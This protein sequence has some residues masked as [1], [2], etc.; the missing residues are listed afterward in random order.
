MVRSLLAALLLALAAEPARAAATTWV[1]GALGDWN[2]PTNWSAGSVPGPAD[3][4]A[5]SVAFVIAY[6]SSPAPSV[7]TLSV[8]SGGVLFTQKGLVSVGA[9]TVHL[10]GAL[11]FGATAPIVLGG[12]VMQSGSSATYVGP[13]VAAGTVPPLHVQAGLFSVAAGSTFTVAARGYA[14]GGLTTAGFGPGG[15]GLGNGLEGG[16]GGGHEAAGANGGGG[17]NAGVSYDG[18]LPTDG[19]SGGG[20]S[21]SAPGGAGGGFLVIDASTAS[22]DG[23]LT[24]DGEV[25]VASGG[26]GGGGGAGGAV[27]LRTAVLTG[28]GRI[29]AAGGA[30]GA[31]ASHGG[32]GG[33]GGAVWITESSGYTVL[34]STLTVSATGGAGG[35][36]AVPGSAAVAGTLYSDPRHWTG[37]GVG[38]FASNPLNWN[39]GILPQGGE[40]LVFGASTTALG[41]TWDLGAVTVGSVTVVNSY[42]ATVTL[43]SSMLVAGTFDMAAG[44]V[45]A[46]PSVDLAVAL[47]LSQT[48]GRL[49]VGV[50]T[51]TVAGAGVS[52]AASFYDAR[53]GILIVGGGGAATATVTGLLDVVTQA[54]LQPGGTL[55]LSTGVLRFEGQGPIYGTG[56]VNSSTSATV[57]AAG[58]IT[59][60][61]NAWP[62]ALGNLRDS[63]VSVTGLVLN[64]GGGAFTLTGGV[65]VDTISSLAF[66]GSR[67]NVGGDWAAY[68]TLFTAGSTVAFRAVVG[69]QTVW[70]GGNFDNLIVDDAGALL[71][72]ASYVVVADSVSLMSGTLDLAVSTL[73]VRGNWTETPG[74]VMLGGA[75]LTLFDGSRPQAIYQVGGNAFGTFRAQN[76]AQVTISSTLA[77]TADFRWDLGNLTYSNA[78]LVIGGNMLTGAGIILNVAGSTVVFN[79]FASTQATNFPQFGDFVDMNYGPYGVFVAANMSCASFRVLPGAVLN[80]G[81]SAVFVA[82]P[83]WDTGRATYT[84]SSPAHQ[85]YWQPTTTLTVGAGSVVNA[86]L[87]LDTGKTAVLNGD[88]NLQ[89]TGTSLD[90]RQGATLINA[91]GG[92]TLAFRGGA[93][94]KPS[95]GANWTYGGDVVDSWLVFEGTGLK[96]A[97]VSTTTF[98]TL[99]VTMNTTT[100]VFKAPSLNLLRGLI[101]ENGTFSASVAPTV[102]VGG[103]LLQ[104]GGVLDFA[105]NSTGTF[106]LTGAAPQNVRLVSGHNALYHFTDLNPTTVTLGS[107][108][109]ARG[110]FTVAAGVFNAGGGNLRL[111]NNVWIATGAVFNGQTSTTTFDGASGGHSSQ[112]LGFYGGGSFGALSF[113]VVTATLLTGATASVLSDALPGASLTVAAGA[114]LTVSDLRVNGTTGGAIALQS[115]AAGTP[116]YLDL[117]SYSSVTSA[118]VSDSNASLGLAVAADD[119]RDVDGGGNTNWKF[120]PQLLVLLPGESFT[121]GAAP[122]KTGAPFLST[123]GVAIPL[124]VLAVSSHYDLSTATGVV[125]LTSDDAFAALGAPQALAGGA[126]A[127]TVTP[128]AA[129]P[130]PRST[131]FTATT[132]FGSGLS[133]GSVI[134]AGLARLQLILPGEAAL[135]GSPTGRTG[136]AFPRVKAVPF[137]ATVRAVDQYWNA[138]T[139]VTDA[140]ALGTA[141]SSATLPGQPPLAAGLSTA[142]GLIFYTTGVFTISA[143]DLTEPGVIAA[144]SSLLGV[145]PPSVSS[146]TASF[147]VPTGASIATL[148]GAI[149]GTAADSSSIALVRVDILEVETGFHYDGISRFVSA[150][151]VFSTTT[152][153]SPLAASTSWSNP[154]PDAALTNGRHYSATALVE[155][156]SGFFGVVASTF[157]V[158]RSALSYGRR[159][160]QGTAAAL[161]GSAPGCALVTATVTFTVGAAGIGPGGAVA[162]RAPDGWT[163]PA[164]LI[165][166]RPPP[167]G[168]WNL[169]STSQVGVIGSSAVLVGPPAFGPQPLGPNWLV[170]AVGTGSAAS[171]LPGQQL[172]FE[173]TGMPPLTPQGRGRQLFQIW[174]TAD[175][176]APLAPISSQP[177]V[178]LTPGATSFLA[179]SDPTPLNLAPLQ[180]STTM[181][182]KV[183]DQCGNDTPGASSATAS[184]SLVVPAGGLYVPDATAAFALPSGLVV[185]T[186]GVPLGAPASQAFTVVTATSGPTMGYVRA[187]GFF[188]V[189]STSIVSVALRPVTF[190]AS[191]EQFSAVSVDSGT[192]VPGNASVSFSAAAPDAYPVRMLFTLTDPALVWD[193]TLSTDA[194]KFNSPVFTASGVGDP[195]K[196]IVLTWDGVD[197]VNGAVIHSAP[198]G[199][200]RLRLRAGGGTAYDASAQ[201]VMPP[202]AGYAGALGPAGA[203]AQ[204]RAVG[205]GAGDGAFTAASSTGYF[206]L[207]GLRTGQSYLIQAA[208]AVVVGG[209]ATT[210][211][212]AVAAPAAAFP[213]ANLGALALPAPARARVAAV[214]PLPAPFDVVGGFIGRAADGSAAF[215]GALR[216]STGS[217]TSD[218]AGPL[219]GRAAS[220]WSVAFAAPGVYTLELD[221]PDLRLSTSIPNVALGGGG[222]D[223][224]VPFSRLASALGYAVLPS[225]AAGGVTLTVQA[226]KAGAAAPSAFASVFVSS[227]PPAV[228]PSSGAYALYGL[229]PGT[230][231]VLASAPGFVS[232]AATVVVAGPADVGMPD[233]PLGYGGA[234][235]GTVTVTGD[236]TGATQCLAGTAGVPGACPAGTFDVAVEALAVGSLGRGATRARLSGSVS[237]S[238]ASFSITGLAPG[239]WKINASLPGFLLTP[240]TGTVV[241]VSAAAVS[242]AAF[243]LTKADARARVVVQLPPL[244][245]GACRTPASYAAVGVTID[246]ADGAS[247]V[248]GD[249]TQA[250]GGG[251]FTAYGC[252]SATVFSPALPPGTARAAALYAP[253]GA[254]GFARAV[255]AGGATATMTLDLTAS[256]VAASGLLSVSG[257]IS[258]A[259]APG[260]A[261]GYSVA[262]SS[263]AGLLSAAPGVSFC[264]L[265]TKDPVP[266]S[267]LRAELLPYDPAAGAPDLRR[268]A[269]GPGSCGPPSVSTTGATSFGFAGAVAADGSFVFA[270]GVQPGTYLLRIPGELD[271]NPNDGPEAAGWSQLVTVGPGGASF[272][273]RLGRGSRVSGAV[274]APPSLP[275]GRQFR[276]SLLGAGGV[277]A[278]G[279]TVAPT[280]GGSAP[281]AFDGVPDGVYALAVGDLSAPRAWAAVNQSVKVAAA[282][283]TGLT[284]AVVAA[285]TI[286]A[287]LAA[288]R[289]LADGTQ[290]AVLITPQTA[291]LLPP[292]FAATA[293]ADPAVAG[294]VYPLRPAPDGSITDAQ[295]RLVFDGL[296]PGTYDVS[297]AAPA[298]PAALGAGAL[299]LAPA[300]V[301]AVAVAPGQA[302]DLGVVP[303]FAGAFVSGL[304]T[305]GASGLPVSGLTVTARP[306]A[307]AA[308]AGAASA[309]TDDAGRFLLRGLDPSQGRY[310]VTAAPRGRLAT[311]DPLPPYAAARVLSVDITSGAVVDFSLSP[312]AATVR[313]TVVAAGGGALSS[314]RGAG[315]PAGPGAVVTLQNGALPPSQD[316]LADLSLRTNPDGSFVIPAVATGSYRLTAS[317]IGA[318]SAV[319]T[320][321]VT[322]AAVDLGTVALGPGAALAGAIRF[323]DGSTPPLSEVVS[324]VAVSPDSSEFLYA[325][326]TTDPTGRFVTGYGVSGLTPGHAY[327]LVVS[328]PGGAAY[329]PPEGAAVVILSSSQAR[330][331]DLTLRPAAGAVTFR[332]SRGAAGWNVVA[333]FPRPLRALYASDSDPTTLLTTAA[334]TGVLS[335]QTLSA[336]RL[337]VSASYSP[338]PG[339]NSAVLLASAALSA[340]DW[341]STSPSARQL[342]A[343]ATTTLA[344]AGDGLTGA[345][346]MNALGGTMTLDGD[347]GRV[348]LPRGAFAVDAATT[349][350]LAFKR[351]ASPAAFAAAPPPGA[352]AGPYYDVSLGGG[353]PS[354]LAHPA[355][356]TLSYSTSAA[357][358]SRLNVYWWNPAA[359]RY[360]LQPDA[361]GAPLTV[362]R[363]A[364]T[365]TLRVGHFSTFVLLDSAA[366]AIGGSAFGGGDL[367]AYNFPN[368]FDLSV[369]TVTTIHGGGAPAVRGTLVRVSVPPGLSGAGTLRVFDVNGRLVRSVDMGALAGGQ[370]YYQVF[371]GRNDAGA[372]VASGLYIAVVDVGGRRKTFKMAVLK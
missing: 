54:E 370:V 209:Y 100:D 264:L 351:S 99:R 97:S 328:G 75:N 277:E 149:A 346:M 225:T 266:R 50:A 36:A 211:S 117:L 360:I 288:I 212:T 322:T 172:S 8:G 35:G 199:T 226:V 244:P 200:Y 24:A 219:F 235:A 142:T 312:A 63:N 337:S 307:S 179:F 105:S 335:A 77:T 170:V 161:P 16:G 41:A 112:A 269:G 242:T 13:P 210:V 122:G 111:Q 194:S 315:D 120:H 229:D 135:P 254:W 114:Q 182:L 275:V 197:R 95:A 30:G 320:V 227:V 127:F 107:D 192:T 47:G 236:S 62:G 344:L 1:G 318:G 6:A 216:F 152:L 247:R 233:L 206:V 141:A 81:G 190:A 83:V 213:V 7:K 57:V 245:G 316:P 48:G 76:T 223:L 11:Q 359:G 2:V 9:T 56:S 272:S 18:V 297:F 166:T 363:A 349:V 71:R 37:A 74:A 123:A 175:A 253:S 238:S 274:T 21:P 180:T 205:P 372:D 355:T 39:G 157:V 279:A 250:A 42:R 133:T 80:G 124:S 289:L 291:G 259:T 251:A 345:A 267:A 171:F 27:V 265:G 338:G 110:D 145:A 168:Y 234:I 321:V 40:R 268:A 189:I 295:G 177:A 364:R 88:L 303:L 341:N 343:G 231:T 151:A 29:S 362:D 317:A 20:G 165:T 256:S 4:A 86:K 224:I 237:A 336:D 280:P 28:A 352:A 79:G 113:N 46:S 160:G 356:L 314:S 214:L 348:V 91:V 119:G 191:A 183:V 306:S 118:A 58:A 85:V 130:N 87:V 188:P 204:V 239:L 241:S 302:V 347:A 292:G 3:D 73:E 52:V 366:G 263:A 65:E 332:A 146:P 137:T 19:G 159:A 222:T 284:A 361:G 104:T 67:L 330:G 220:T 150:S 55:S 134:P 186:V 23:F 72:L 287:R 90:I 368:P 208:T 69:T 202:T 228:G 290:Q 125:T 108:F 243:S 93:D 106:T 158:D 285:G 319:R 354:A 286:R 25:G 140:Y 324:L 365:V 305:D 327:R 17:S 283:V 15:G 195:A 296:L 138:V 193:A 156:P 33:G 293:T 153:A 116:W 131:H 44:T 102:K 371:D 309:T 357:D 109:I 339:E 262:A 181:T 64:P 84:V 89:G 121:P 261:P 34:R 203:F 167:P 59:Q 51:L 310:D 174:T 311:G 217:A 173:Y 26:F 350:A 325:A 184:L 66:T 333:A 207:Q 232:T 147:Y 294:G 115:S 278:R 185:S 340:T 260:G 240:A 10:G 329:V 178:N 271:D 273:A 323:P 276:V 163:V 22:I 221:L 196:P 94:F 49:D 98:G 92:S 218:D 201:V 252:S 270:P 12:L 304:V 78:K 342:V 162:V 198:A 282:D 164:G 154:V 369:K 187:S 367:D 126:A 155:D 70:A 249:V 53:A 68:G 301:T 128:F 169:I 230:W 14:G 38:A 5:L 148:G 255:L 139:T 143:T 358:P 101:L 176:T 136:Q 258:V 257:V 299:A 45:T 308:S 248:F 96:G 331:L 32:G 326:L 334:A 246:A 60:T 353:I 132:F 103:D 82:G 313:G 300:R 129:E 31:G 215:S 43:A 144:T 61:W 298:G 281:F